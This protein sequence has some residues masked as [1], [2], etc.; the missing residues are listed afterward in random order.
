M[1]ETC[2]Q[3]LDRKGP[4]EKEM[5]THSNMAT[6]SNMA[7]HSNGNPLQNPMD[8]GAWWDAVPGLARVGHDLAT[9]TT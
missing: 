7:T 9:K 1:Q 8:T 5:A 3:F 2:V 6:Y 4:L